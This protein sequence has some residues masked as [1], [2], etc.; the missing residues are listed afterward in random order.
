MSTAYRD[1]NHRAAF[2]LVE[3]LV[4]ITIIGI[5]V[6]LLMPAVQSARESGRRTQCINNLKQLGTAAQQH[7]TE[8]NEQLPTGGWGWW[9]VGDPE[10]G[11]R[12]SQPGG[13]LYNI[14][15]FI[16]QKNVYMLPSDMERDKITEQQKQGAL[17]M[18]QTPLTMVNCPSRRLAIL[19]TKNWDGSYV[20]RNCANTPDKNTPIGRTDYA[21]NTGSQSSVQYQGGPGDP[22]EGSIDEKEKG[23]GWRDYSGANGICFERSEV[24]MSQIRDGETFTIMFGEKYLDPDRYATGNTASDNEHMYTGYNN[25][26]YR[27]TKASYRPM[28]DTPGTD[29]HVNFGSPHPSGCNFVFCDGHVGTIRYN[30]DPAIYEHLGNRDGGVHVELTDENN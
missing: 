23:H 27:S 25:D 30:I 19:Y 13:W 3:L 12:K 17:E 15:P 21:A 24:K 4:V 1:K 22:G 9:W 20:G 5:L 11:F 29:Q 8:H 2:T 28:R 6:S 7:A 10:R 16:E 14:L 26:I 18:I